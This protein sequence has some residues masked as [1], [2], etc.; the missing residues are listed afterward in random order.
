MPP[1]TASKDF[2]MNQD[3]QSW[4][5]LVVVFVT[6]L[7]FAFRAWKKRR[8]RGCGGGCDCGKKS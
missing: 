8:V 5:A 1:M 4:A 6:L 2:F 3:S 7:A